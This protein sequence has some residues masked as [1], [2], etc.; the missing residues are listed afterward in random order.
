MRKSTLLLITLSILGCERYG[1]II[2]SHGSVLN[3]IDYTDDGEKWTEHFSYDSIGRLV[4]ILDTKNSGRKYISVFNEEKLL[5]FTTFTVEPNKEIERDSF[6]YNLSGQMERIYKFDNGSD[7]ADWIYEYTY[8]A[9]GRLETRKTILDHPVPFPIL[10]NYYWEN[11]NV[12]HIEEFNGEGDLLY[13]FFC[14]YDDKQNYKKVI[15][16]YMENPVNWSLNN[17]VSVTWNDYKGDFE[18]QCRGCETKYN[19]N[20]DGSPLE[21]LYP[22]ERELKL[23]FN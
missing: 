9:S 19:Y 11:G 23:D 10:E 1:D 4:E 7:K 15:P 6:A 17:L 20:L 21:I 8:D 5:Q 12:I 18:G 16:Y 22:W 3:K 2:D 14:I 13:E